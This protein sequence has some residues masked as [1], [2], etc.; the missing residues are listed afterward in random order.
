MMKSILGIDRAGHQVPE[1]DYSNGESNIILFL[2]LIY[3]LRQPK[4]PMVVKWL[5]KLY[6]TS[7]V[8]LVYSY[9]DGVHEEYVATWEVV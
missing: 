3:L 7:L 4:C 5:N 8:R 2:T 9:K 1:D 6:D